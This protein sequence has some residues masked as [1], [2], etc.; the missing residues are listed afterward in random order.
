MEL[1]LI[2]LLFLSSTVNGVE[3]CPTGL[4]VNVDHNYYSF[5]SVLENDYLQI[6]SN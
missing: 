1:I 5:Y 6:N 2:A 4:Y 3:L